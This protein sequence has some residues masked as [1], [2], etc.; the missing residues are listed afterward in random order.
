MRGRDP[1]DP[2][3]GTS[4]RTIVAWRHFGW[5]RSDADRVV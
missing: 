2:H 4:G 1:V 5:R 3:C